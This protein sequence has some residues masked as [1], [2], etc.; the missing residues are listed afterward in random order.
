MST[1]LDYLHGLYEHQDLLYAPSQP[2]SHHETFETDVFIVGGGNA[3]VAL[4]ARLK[5]SGVSNV[6]ADRNANVGDNWALRYDSLRFHVPTP[7]CE[8]PY[9]GYHPKLQDKILSRDDLT[10][11]LKGYYKLLDLHVINSVKITKTTLSED[12]RWR[13][14]FNWTWG[15]RTAIAKHLVQAT[16]IGSQVPYTPSISE[17]E[18][19]GGIAMHSSLYQNAHALKA[20]GIQSVC[21]VGSASTAFDVLEDCYNAGLNVTMVVRSAQY[22]VPLEYICHEHGLGAYKFS[23]EKVDEIFMMMPTIVDSQLGQKLFQQLASQEPDRYLALREAGFPV[24]DSR[25]P[26][27]ALMNHLIECGGGHYVDTGATKL[28]AESKVSFRADVEPKAYTASGFRL[29]DGTTLDADAMIWCP[30]FAD[31]DA[32]ETVADIMKISL[33]VDAAWG[34]DEEGEIR[35]IWKRHS[36]VANYWFMGGFTQQHRWYSNT[37]AQQIKASPAGVL[38]PPY[39][40]CRSSLTEIESQATVTWF[41]Y[42]SPDQ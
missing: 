21:V 29:S 40:G 24:I 11:H 31:K 3:A 26:D 22:V 7:Y 42:S 13:I 27:A 28:L 34:V 38:P 20:Q 35:G 10:A 41:Q 9:D 14:E 39:V 25:D 37:L 6:M 18:A 8:L 17:Q 12:G 16:E 2:L 30:G 5:A 19:Y 23:V 1:R 32:R 33:P 15:T 4:A 36:Q